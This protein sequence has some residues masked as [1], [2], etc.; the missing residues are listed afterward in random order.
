[1]EISF[2]IDR[3]PSI[4][5][6]RVYQTNTRKSDKNSLSTIISVGVVGFICFPIDWPEFVGNATIHLR[7]I[8]KCF[9]PLSV[10]VCGAKI[11]AFDRSAV[12]KANYF[13][14]IVQSK[15][16][17]WFQTHWKF[18]HFQLEHQHWKGYRSRQ[19]WRPSDNHQLVFQTKHT[20]FCFATG[21]T[22]NWN[23]LSIES[24][25]TFK[26]AALFMHFGIMLHIWD[27]TR[28]NNFGTI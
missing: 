15:P 7:N 26:T 18:W 13:P 20:T 2:D 25:F 24:M 5:V 6:H 17:K 3:M 27:L 22:L 11:W 9:V 28:N 21:Y 4:S 10:C 1:M 14:S 19:G 12:Q 23:S 8:A 16:W